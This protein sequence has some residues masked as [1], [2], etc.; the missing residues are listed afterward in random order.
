[1]I[2]M[3]NV[4]SPRVVF[5]DD[6]PGSMAAQCWDRSRRRWLYVAVFADARRGVVFD[7]S[8][9]ARRWYRD[10]ADLPELIESENERRMV[11]SFVKTEGL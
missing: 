2:A 9:G 5:G 6:L 11:Q 4:V 1:M 3:M 7:P 10:V 8:T